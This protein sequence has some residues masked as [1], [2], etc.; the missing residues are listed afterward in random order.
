MSKKEKN[1]SSVEE[2]IALY[3]T[4]RKGKS[5]PSLT[6]STPEEQEEDNYAYWR[7][8]TPKQ[9]LALHLKMAKKVFKEE[10]KNPN[11]YDRIYFDRCI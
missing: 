8:L 4:S 1:S 7:R 5:K 6:I 2:P 10:L 9:R 3:I 11:P